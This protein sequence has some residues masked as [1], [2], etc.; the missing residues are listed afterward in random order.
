MTNFFQ[1]VRES[2]RWPAFAAIAGAIAVAGVAS[3]AAASAAS[4]PSDSRHHHDQ[5]ECVVSI[6]DHYPSQ[7]AKVGVTVTTVVHGH[8]QVTA[9]FKTIN[10]AAAYTAGGRHTFWFSVGL[11]PLGYKVVVDIRTSDGRRAGS[12]QTWFTPRRN[13]HHHPGP[14]P[15]PSPTQSH[16]PT[17]TPPPGPSGDSGIPE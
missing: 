15:S 4:R 5:L 1:A 13:G 10:S 12:C 11:A 14:A 17:P 16:V 9:H 2:R 8:I 6:T 3:T 7:H